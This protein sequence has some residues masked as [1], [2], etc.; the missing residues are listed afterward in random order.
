MIF[1]HFKRFYAFVK[2][3]LPTLENP[4]ITIQTNF[5]SPMMRCLSS[6]GIPLN[7]ALLSFI[8]APSVCSKPQP[9]CDSQ[10]RVLMCSD[11]NKSHGCIQGAQK[12]KPGIIAKPRVIRVTVSLAW[13]S[14]AKANVR[15]A[16]EDV[17]GRGPVMGLRSIAR[18]RNSKV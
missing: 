18:F 11:P 5:V 2:T 7:P 15:N 17:K 12:E 6:P 8:P 10:P 3:T 9:C 13:P 16:V 4:M 1:R 14:K